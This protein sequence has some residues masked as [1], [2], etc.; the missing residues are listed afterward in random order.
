MI[1]RR[2]IGRGDSHVK[3]EEALAKAGLTERL[4]IALFDDEKRGKD[5]GAKLNQWG[6]E[7]ADA[8]AIANRGAHAG[9]GGS[10]DELV[11]NAQRLCV[12]IQALA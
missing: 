5:V 9:Y 7:F 2:W 8:W 10:L 3:V 6:V 12:K 11:R 4:A 1:R